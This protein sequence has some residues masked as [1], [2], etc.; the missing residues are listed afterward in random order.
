LRKNFE[1][2]AD[3]GI[4]VETSTIS[5]AFEEAALGFSEIITGGN[6][7]K[8]LISNDVSIESDNLDSL[9]VHFISYLVVLFDTDL[10]ISGFAKIEI[11]KGENFL[12]KGI[13]KGDIYDQSKH[14]Y[15]VEIKAVSYHQLLVEEGPPSRLRVIL[16]L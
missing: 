2:T 7:P 1:H 10:F 9:L 5:R 4:E 15:G 14:G 8:E 13:L 12:L 6:L 11:F 3:I 16:D